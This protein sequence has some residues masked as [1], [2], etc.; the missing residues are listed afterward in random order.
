MGQSE[1]QFGYAGSSSRSAGGSP[2]LP[3]P[4]SA[5]ADD[6]SLVERLAAHR[7]IGSIPREELEWLASHGRLRRLEPGELISPRSQPVSA[8]YVLLTGRVSIHYV[9]AGGVRH[10]VA[11]WR[12]GDV[13]GFLPYSR[14]TTPPGDSVVEEPTEVLE[15]P[16]DEMRAMT[17]ACHELTTILV[18]V[19]LDRARFFTS[20][21]LH[22]AKLKSLGKLAAGLAHELNNP[23]AAITRSAKLLPD[24]VRAAQAAAR[25]LGE[26]RLTSAEAAAIHEAGLECQEVRVQQVQSPLEEAER[27]AAIAAWL[28]AHHVNKVDAE[29]IA[30][31]PVAL[32]TLERLAAAIRPECLGPALRHVAAECWV[33]GLAREIEQ[34]GVRISELVKAVRG[35]TRVDSSSVPQP[36]DISEGLTETLSV[37]RGKARGKGIRISVSLADDLVPVRGVAAEL[38][39]VWANLID[40][41]LDAAPESGSVEVSAVRENEC[42]VVRVVDDGP[43]IPAEIRERVFEPFFT[44]KDVGKGTGLGLDIVRR[45]VE[46][47]DGDIDVQSRPGR[48]EFAVSLPVAGPNG[49]GGRRN[50][51]A[52]DSRG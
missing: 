31:T 38:N 20:A 12:A 24:G 35:F 48:T 18:H 2:P 32:E 52:R 11:E 4:G 51:E 29:T 43:G 8:M 25:E 22:D 39:Q 34:A 19:M 16:R 26:A 41:A 15:V 50:D 40:N 45:L 13:T 6:N 42:V 21:M 1:Q 5:P 17:R 23:S 33:R 37:L 27:E 7:T 47:H 36:V 3:E 9:G 49:A 46:R 10:K 30:Q 14:M 44:T 28:E